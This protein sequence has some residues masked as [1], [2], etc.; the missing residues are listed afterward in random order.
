M[1]KFAEN[2]VSQQSQSYSA[3]TH[4]KT[5]SAFCLSLSSVLYII[6]EIVQDSSEDGD[7]GGCR[8]PQKCPW[9][10]LKDTW[11]P[12]FGSCQVEIFILIFYALSF[13]IFVSSNCYSGQISK[14]QILHTY[15]S[16]N[17]SVRL[18]NQTSIF[19]PSYW[20]CD[21]WQ[22]SLVS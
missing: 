4:I 16:F 9:I 7:H 12:L 1:G 14:S 17:V 5:A 10:L 15:Q 21:W 11:F 6:S 3:H 2:T 8:D 13:E 18:F 22:A 20:F 19:Q